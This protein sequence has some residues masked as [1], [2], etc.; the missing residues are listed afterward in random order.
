MLRISRLL[1]AVLVV[2]GVMAGLAAA[3]GSPKLELLGPLGHAYCDGTTASGEPGDWGFVTF[4]SPSKDTIAATVSLKNAQPNAEFAVFLIQWE[5]S[6]C[7][8]G[9][10]G[11]IAT[12]AQGN[13]SV[14]V[15][16]PTAGTWAVVSVY[17]SGG[18]DEEFVT[19][20]WQH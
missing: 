1:V 10:D 14:R 3:D 20:A 12:N 19:A 8:K 17:G 18:V 7:Y 11:W 2:A 6:S 9:I 13:G 4:S 5:D 16:A 15:S